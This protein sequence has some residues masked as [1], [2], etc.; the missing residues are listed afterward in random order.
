MLNRIFL[1]ILLSAIKFTVGYKILIYS[2]QIGYSHVFFWG[3][4]ADTLA[5]AG[6][7]VVS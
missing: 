2:P 6:H 7:D 4:V 3:S 1:L 5:K